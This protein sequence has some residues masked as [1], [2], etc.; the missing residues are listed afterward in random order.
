[1]RK[2]TI[3][4]ALLCA[5]MM[6][7]AYDL[8]PNTNF[9]SQNLQWQEIAGITPPAN[10]VNVQAHEGHD[11]LYITF[12]D[13][14]FN[15][16]NIGGGAVVYTDAGAQA[17]LQLESFTN[18][19]TDVL[20]Y[21]TGSTTDVRWG[22]RIYNA[23][24]GGGGSTPGTI[25]W[26]DVSFV[27]GSS[28]YKVGAL[29]AS[30][31]P[32]E[33][34][35]IQKPG[36][37]EEQGIYMTFPSADQL[38]CSLGAAVSG[39]GMVVYL[40]NF[41]G[42]EETEVTVTWNGGSKTFYVYN[43]APM[44][45]PA[46]KA[47]APA[48]DAQRV[49]AVYSQ[50]AYNTGMTMLGWSNE[51]TKTD[52]RVEGRKFPS[53]K[54]GNYLGLG[55]GT[56]NVSKMDNIHLDIWTE[57]S[58]TIN[59]F[60][61]SSGQE[62]YYNISLTGGKWNS[63][64]IPLSHYDNVNMEEVDEFKIADASIAGQTIFV[65][66]IYFYA[67]ADLPDPTPSEIEDTNFALRTNGAISYGSTVNGE[68]YP[69]RAIDGNTGTQWESAWD[70]D[71]QWFVVD[72]GQ[73]RIFN[74]VNI[75]WGNQWSSE[76]Y[77]ETSNN[78]VDW[79]EVKHVTGNT[80][81]HVNSQQN[82]E[83]DAT[84][85]SRYIRFRGIV[86]ANGYGYTIKEFDVLKTGTPVLTSVDLS[87]DKKIAKVGEYATLTASP[88]DQNS[89][90]IA[91]TLTYTVSPAD[92]GHVTDGKYYPEKYGLAT[93]TVTA[94]AGGESVNNSVQIW[95]VVSDNLAL[96]NA[97]SEVG[98]WYST[99]TS[100]RAVDG[101]DNTEWQGSTENGNIGDSK[102][103][104]AWFVVDLK[105]NYNLQLIT[106]HFEGA[107][108]DA[109]ELYGST[110]NSDWTKIYTWAYPTPGAGNRIDNHTDWISTADLNNADNV[111]YLKFL[112]TRA[113][114]EWGVKMLEMEVYGAE[115]S[116]TKT[117]A[118][119][120]TPAA[121]GAVTIT[122]AGSPVTEV[123]SGTV[124]TFTA[125]PNSGYDFVNWTQ[126]SVEVSAD[127]EYVTTITSNTALVAN[128]ET[129]RTA[130]C[131][132]PLNTTADKTLYLTITNPSANTYKILLEGS[133]DNKIESAYNNFNFVLSHI[134]G[135]TG[136]TALPAA[137]WTI[138]NS[139]YGSAY[140]TFTAENFRE[141]TFVNKY[142]VFD[143][144]GGGL[145]EFNAFPD[146]NL[147]KWDAT[148][149]D[150]EAPVLAAPTASPLSGTSVRLALSA[151]D[152]MAALLTYK[153]TYEGLATP[154]EV[155]GA[156]G[157]VT[158]YNV[159]G[160]SAG[161][162]YTFSVTVSDGTNVS[163]AQTCSATPSMPTA[164]MPTHP[165]NQVRSIY[166]D[167]YPSA[168]EHDYNKNSWS[169]IPYT[170]LNVSGDQILLFNTETAK[171]FSFGMND[172]GDA[173]II[174]KEMYNDGVNKGLDVRQLKYLHVDIWTEGSSVGPV[175]NI[176]DDNL[177]AF[178]IEGSGWHSYDF[179]LN[180]LPAEKLN[181]V[182][183]MGFAGFNGLNSVAIDN[184]YFWSDGVPLTPEEGWATYAPAE[185]VSVPT[186]ITAY[187]AS[188]NKEGSDEQLVLH[189]ITE[190]VIP[191][192]TGVILKG[193]PGGFG[194][195]TATDAAAPSFSENILVG[196]P[197]QTDISA[198]AANNDIFCLRYSELYS[199]T[200]FFLYGGTVIGAGKA[201][202]PL[203]KESGASGAPRRMRFVIK[204]EQTATG[205]DSTVSQDGQAEKFIENGQ[206]F[207][208]RGDVVYTIQGVRVK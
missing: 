21:Q 85:T 202:L 64:D 131:A 61:H 130:Y 99:Y 1:M 88:K 4:F 103:Y 90:A 171:W 98:T 37:A 155:P 142:V 183:W 73:R 194:N 23:A 144:Q 123:A 153:I 84:A 111:R 55:Y 82:F 51:M 139:G 160:L 161:T 132:V 114:T 66:N 177:A 45:L 206:L 146:A 63:V 152:N 159:T 17:W 92:A 101:N 192:G 190:N 94:E 195:F 87:S 2:L 193:T 86:R 106:I 151:T 7:W 174:A 176:N 26:N 93:I 35:N 188:Y 184:V 20:F 136:N 75:Y 196:C 79:T 43:N 125:T 76:F 116:S 119:T 53:F 208:R 38:A 14:G 10:V 52:V 163:A 24:A 182:R 166:S 181:N 59:F 203:P 178:N 198:I 19:Y 133:A 141:V 156:A 33:V 124:V 80:E 167:A 34:V 11:C 70:S 149:T 41:L 65:D 207:I 185:K 100:S 197:V 77:L 118:A 71:P 143:K 27:T 49:R 16:D 169:W 69:G 25:D 78:G 180:A 15:R 13:A 74:N 199:M 57:T 187:W 68:N 6:S 36:W 200:G 102:I 201:Y 204:N 28:Q 48:V 138:D 113:A 42:N 173:A 175:I 83:L 179:P 67:N 40:S 117:V 162:N 44:T 31:M 127:L 97:L 154:I 22:L 112:S 9:G 115:A 148:C 104:D 121:S 107:C 72:F 129:H 39:A 81:N 91:A 8:A 150:D 47:P 62:K 30:D 158:Y 135:E 122:A 140:V 3:L 191:A 58:H 120:V 89:S 145:T 56:L 128:F 165:K 109:Y 54:F 95:G 168:L 164:P 189:E 137:S 5:S 96:N 172:N 60:I 46:T 157:E 32:N 186:G 147:I 205:I 108:S 12:V 50:Y 126:G 105:G 134:N 170:T 18:E 110:N 29:S